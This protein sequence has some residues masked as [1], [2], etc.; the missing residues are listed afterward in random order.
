MANNSVATKVKVCQVSISLGRGGAERFAAL[1]STMLYQLGYEVTTV[2]LTNEL[3]YAYSGE[4]LNL[5][6]DKEK[7]NN[8]FT[9]LTRFNKF[10]KFLKEEQFDV[11]IDH[12]PKNQWAKELFY[13]DYIYKNQKL[14]YVVHNYMLDNYMTNKKWMAKRMVKNT[15]EFVGVSKEISQ[16]L[17]KRYPKIKIRTIYN[18]SQE[19]AIEKPEEWEWR[20]NYILFLGRLNS[21]A[22]NLALLIEAYKLSELYEKKIPLL[23]IGAGNSEPLKEQIISL[24]L[25]DSISIISFTDQVGYYLKQA[26]FLVLSSRNEGFPMVLIESLSVGTPVVSVDCKSGPK[27]VIQHERNGLLVPNFDPQALAIAMKRMHA[28]EELYKQCKE[29]AKESIVHL[30][31]DAIAKE[32]VEVIEEVKSK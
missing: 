8:L 17:R 2:I 26:K 29:F 14:I 16:E 31:I 10:R 20:S 3:N 25:E 21:P 18:P 30:E 12:R 11:I 23:L 32:W 24:G 6:E 7:S 1:L 27:E 4:L 15:D 5:G 13:L 9:R 19:L 22:K 28:D